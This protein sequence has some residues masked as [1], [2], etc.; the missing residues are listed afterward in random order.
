MSIGVSDEDHSADHHSWSFAYLDILGFKDIVK[1]NSF[2]QLK[3]IVDDFT[4]GFA[5]AADESRSLRFYEYTEPFAS[6]CYMELVRVMPAPDQSY[7][8]SEMRNS[9]HKNE[10][11]K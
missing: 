5:K 3:R 2:E 1:R 9:N 11:L 4:V 7:A 8:M 10:E 6:P